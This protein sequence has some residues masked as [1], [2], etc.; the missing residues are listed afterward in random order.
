[1]DQDEKQGME[2]QPDEQSSEPTV[3]EESDAEQFQS[4]LEEALRERGQF[5]A[6]LQRVQADFANYKKRAEEEW[7]Q[8]RHRATEHLVLKLLPVLD[9]FR[10]A[11][12]HTLESGDDSQW[13][14]GVR[15]LERKLWSV[16]ESE[17]LT[18]IEAEDKQ[19][20]PSEHEA[21]F[22]QETTDCEDGQVLSVIRE[23]YILQGRVLRA[24]QVSVARQLTTTPSE[25]ESSTPESEEDRE[26][27]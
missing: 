16:L 14:E 18:R 13:V 9:D 21:L 26:E 4:E 10:L 25:E 11:L 24:V 8:Q 12:D 1:M 6:L 5:R 20:D 3:S 22:E 19:F 17:G 7:E 23:G 15:L 27:T 2:Q